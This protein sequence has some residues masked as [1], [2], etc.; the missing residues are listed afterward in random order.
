MNVIYESFVT[1]I[2][3]EYSEWKDGDR[4]HIEEATSIDWSFETGSS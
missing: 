3:A 2:K 1:I 4:L